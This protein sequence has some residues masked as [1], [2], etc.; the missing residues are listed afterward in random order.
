MAAKEFML[1]GLGGELLEC[2]HTRRNSLGVIG[3]VNAVMGQARDADGYDG[4][5]EHSTASIEPGQ[6]VRLP[7]IPRASAVDNDDSSADSGWRD[8]LTTPRELPEE[9]LRTLEARQAAAWISQQIKG[10]LRPEQVMVLSR[11]RAGLLPLQDELRALHI[12][13]QI[14]EKTEL[15]DCCEVLDVV[16]LL[17]VLVSPQHDLSLARALR[18]PLFGLSDDALMTIALAKGES[19]SSW[20]D[21]VQGM[22]QNQELVTPV[23]I[24]LQPDL[25]VNLALYK[26]FLDTFPPHDA[27]QAIY[28]HGDVLAKFSAAAPASSRSTVLANLRALL[29]A[30]LQL[31]GGRYATPYAFVRALKAGGL[32]APAAVNPNAVRL[33]TIHG[34]KGLEAEAVLLLDTDT[35][36]RNADSM[37]VLIDW[38]GQAPRP[39]KFVFLVSESQP[40]ACAQEALAAEQAARQREE[41]NALYVALTRAK[42]TLGVSS[43]AP[44]RE[45]PH[46]WWQRLCPLASEVAVP[47]PASTLDDE[48]DIGQASTFQLPDLPAAPLLQTS[49]TKPV[50]SDED[51]ASARVGKAM[52]RLLERGDG[53]A[54]QVQRVAREFRLDPAQA[55][56][57]AAAARRILAGEGAWAWDE[58]VIAWQGNEVEL[59]HAGQTLRLDRLVQRKDAG[60]AGHWWVLDYKSTND[61]LRQPQLLEQLRGY[62]TAVEQIYPGA[63]VKAAFL[64]GQGAVL[65]VSR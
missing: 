53:S 23:F 11:K 16:A 37:S 6:V 27:L 9:T 17:D 45:A 15:I 46:S 44:F 13:A 40:P 50:A 30:S 28:E 62:R 10:G 63:I 65:E 33:L 58:A 52:H 42:S 25:A 54:A 34:A 49:A 47:E 8:S 14:G 19:T 2:D 39:Q 5:R 57:A 12:P 51:S 64:T 26:H 38:P 59:T 3:A 56:E 18:S 32:Q 35:A 1:D 48:L 4:F 41:L 31:D 61:P 24:G 21:L 36:E 20:W 60:H 7:P 55:K 43:I 29:S 22:L